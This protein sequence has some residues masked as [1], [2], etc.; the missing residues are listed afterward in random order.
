MQT[1]R[2]GDV[3]SHDV[4]DSAEYDDAAPPV[5]PVPEIRCGEARRTRLMMWI[6]LSFLEV[7]PLPEEAS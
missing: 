5:E 7:P 2:S 6:I 1:A 4:S 3:S